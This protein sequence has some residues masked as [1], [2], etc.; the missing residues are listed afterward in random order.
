MEVANNLTYY[1]PA[2]ITAVKSFVIQA[3][4]KLKLT[5]VI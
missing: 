2:T 1:D 4:G 3:L 5:A